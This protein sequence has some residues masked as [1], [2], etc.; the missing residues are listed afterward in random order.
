MNNQLIPLIC[1]DPVNFLNSLTFYTALPERN[2]PAALLT[3]VL[4]VR[5]Y[6]ESKILQIAKVLECWSKFNVVYLLPTKQ[7]MTHS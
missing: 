7:L 6:L 3:S 2:F 5:K 4:V 1:Y